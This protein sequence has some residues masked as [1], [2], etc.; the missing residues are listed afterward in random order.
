M[1][2]TV[3]HARC[4]IVAST[5]KHIANVLIEIKMD[6]ASTMHID[7]SVSTNKSAKT[8]KIRRVGRERS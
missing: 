8:H 1:D 5:Q 4:W 7:D 2:H 6:M 3:E